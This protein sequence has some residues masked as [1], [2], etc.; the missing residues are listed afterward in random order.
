MRG[1]PASLASSAKKALPEIATAFGIALTCVIGVAYIPGCDA[2]DGDS[3]GDTEAGTCGNATCG[4]NQYC[5]V[6]PCTAA[7]ACTPSTDTSCPDGTQSA[8]CNGTPGCMQINCAPIA[9]G[10][11]DL[12]SGCGGTLSCAC[13]GSACGTNASSCSEA[14]AGVVYCSGT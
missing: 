11:Q 10:C 3:S 8:D 13:I 14:D 2:L 12:P 9:Q 6:R 5:L 4:S 1:S 7:E